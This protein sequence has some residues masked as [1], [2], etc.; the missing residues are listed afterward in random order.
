MTL[1]KRKVP[2]KLQGIL[3]SVDVN[4]LDLQKDK[5]YII[6]QIFTYG[7]MAEIHWLFNTYSK[8]TLLDV[9]IRQ[10]IKNYS[11]VRFHFVKNYFLGIKNQPLNKKYYV[12]NIPRDIQ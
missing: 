9:F 12:K 3:W 7:T 2:K 8:K 6:N 11:A 1:V 10:P 4:Q 5:A